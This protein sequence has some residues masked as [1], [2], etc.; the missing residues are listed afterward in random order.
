MAFAWPNLDESWM[1][2]H[3]VLQQVAKTDV[4]KGVA[5]AK[6][7]YARGKQ[8]ALGPY[9]PPDGRIIFSPDSTPTFPL[10]Q[11]IVEPLRETLYKFA[12]RLTNKERFEPLDGWHFNAVQWL[13]SICIR[14]EVAEVAN[15]LIKGWGQPI[16]VTKVLRQTLQRT[17]VRNG[18]LVDS[19]TGF[20]FGL[21]V[22]YLEVF[23]EYADIVFS[24]LVEILKPLARPVTYCLSINPLDILL[25]SAATAGW[26]SC[27]NILKG[28]RK[29][30]AL[31]YMLDSVTATCYVFSRTE[32]MTTLQFEYPQMLWRQLVH[33]DAQNLSAFHGRHFPSDQFEYSRQARGLSAAV[34]AKMGRLDP[35][36]HWWVRKSYD[37]I[38][39][40]NEREEN[41]GPLDGWDLAAPE[42]LYLDR[43]R[44]AIRLKPTSKWP[45]LV[46]G[47]AEIPCV[48][49]GQPRIYRKNE[50]SW[51]VLVCRNCRGY[52]CH[53]CHVP[54][55]RGEEQ[56]GSDWQ[57][58][59]P[60]CFQQHFFNCEHCNA[61][62]FRHYGYRTTTTGMACHSC[63]RRYYRRCDGCRLMQRKRRRVVQG[64]RL[65]ALCVQA[66]TVRCDQ[67]RGRHLRN[68]RCDRCQ[69]VA[70]Y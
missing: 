63:V 1:L 46:V 29:C 4:V 39:T 11:D 20:L 6:E 67:C 22:A 45:R 68:H 57:R 32:I 61:L 31:S 30:G 36:I 62:E 23:M 52:E 33:F 55:P 12:E 64:L 69:Q 9:F 19:A 65:C 43:P 50:E 2:C 41:A 25:M 14:Y 28:G 7:M 42:W 13:L 49:C 56:I 66:Y 24:R 48:N 3:R 21:P 16:S 53:A 58:Y 10:W 60:Q 54:I 51:G 37:D 35:P 17:A 5:T 44:E 18:L 34:L 38:G 47:V 59:C 8:L 26:T 70:I 15:N 40:K 27:H